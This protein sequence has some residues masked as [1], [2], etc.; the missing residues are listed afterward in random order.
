MAKRESRQIIIAKRAALPQELRALEYM[1]DSIIEAVIELVCASLIARRKI[2]QAEE[3]AR[4]L[5][6]YMNHMKAIGEYLDHRDVNEEFADR[7]QINNLATTYENSHRKRGRPPEAK[8]RDLEI[9]AAVAVLVNGRV[10][11]ATRSHAARRL[12]DASACNIV[13]VA[14]GR[15]GEHMS[16]RTIEGIWNRYKT[17]A[18]IQENIED[19]I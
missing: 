13:Q 5:R 19:P 6:K 1:R 14:L 16:E 7:K 12:K 10:F 3:Y 2:T 9:A 18:I 4:E 11:H 17:S 15:L 8:L